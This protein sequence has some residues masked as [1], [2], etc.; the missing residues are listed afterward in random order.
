MYGEAGFP[1]STAEALIINEKFPGARLDLK[2]TKTLNGR[3]MFGSISPKK[4]LDKALGTIAFDRTETLALNEAKLP[5]FSRFPEIVV[6]PPG[7]EVEGVNC[8]P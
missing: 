1:E 4:T 6:F 8:K 3:G 7:V 2:T 5:L